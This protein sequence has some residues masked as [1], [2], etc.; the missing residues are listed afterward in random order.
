[1]IFATEITEYTEKN[2]SLAL[3]VI[4]DETTSHST[5]AGKNSSQV[6]GYVFSVANLF[7]D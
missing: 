2:I 1:M 3:S 5:K 4:S 7:Y 6:A